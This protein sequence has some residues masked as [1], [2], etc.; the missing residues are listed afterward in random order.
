MADVNEVSSTLIDELDT[1]GPLLGIVLILAGLFLMLRGYERLH[2]VAGATGAGI[3]YVLTPTLSTL[4]PVSY[5]H[6]TLPT[7][8]YV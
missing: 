4:V 7:T 1:L 5:T 8:P 6:L 2:Y 3:G